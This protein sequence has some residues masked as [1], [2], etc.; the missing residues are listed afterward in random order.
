MASSRKSRFGKEGNPPRSIHVKFYIPAGT[1][2]Q[3]WRREMETRWRTWRRHC[4]L[5]GLS[6]GAN[7]VGGDWLRPR[8]ECFCAF[9]LDSTKVWIAFPWCPFRPFRVLGRLG[10]ER[11]LYGWACINGYFGS[12]T[13]RRRGAS[14]WVKPVRQG[15][16]LEK[17]DS[18][19]TSYLLSVGQEVVEHQKMD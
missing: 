3:L 12:K 14:C 9:R 16:P 8:C 10:T 11:D 6:N 18:V 1:G 5:H 2:K 15:R 17:F 4:Q 7:Y 19:G 13:S